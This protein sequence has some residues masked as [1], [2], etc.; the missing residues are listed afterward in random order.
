MSRIA[1][2]IFLFL[3]HF[4]CNSKKE[5]SAGQVTV[6]AYQMDKYL[7]LIEGKTVGLCVNH[8]SLV[9]DRHLVD[10]LLDLGITVSKIFTPEHGFRGTA[11]AGEKVED[12]KNDRFDVVSLYGE[13]RK[14]KSDQL[15]NI[16]VMVFDIQDVGVRFYTYIGTMHY[17]MESCAENGIPVI[18]LDRPNPNGSYVDGPVLDTAYSS[19]VGMHPVPIVHGMTIGEYAEMI[20]GED[21][22]DVDK[23]LDLT[24]IP[25]QNWDHSKP[26]SLPVRPS[27]N[28]PNDLAISLYPSLCLFEGTSISIGRGT[29]H[30]FQIFGHPDMNGPFQF[31]PVSGFGA[32]YPKL[33]GKQCLGRSMVGDQPIYRLDLSYLIDSYNQI[34]G[35]EEFFNSYFNTLAGGPS[36]KDQITSNM[37]EDQIRK[38]WELGLSNYE[39]IREKYLL[40]PD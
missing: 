24:I 15:E 17:V 35:S 9:G 23:S 3:L 4:S 1:F 22:L 32:K 29:D 11:D 2:L 33:E 39:K 38:S 31:T 18:I 40:Y 16:D 25:I 8:T 14:P 6:G 26:Y 13:S 5:E 36:L 27:P 19:F 20:V 10:T 12:E 37:P 21:W 7:P 28:L 34:G 30:P